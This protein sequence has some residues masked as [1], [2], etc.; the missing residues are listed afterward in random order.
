M[1]LT[2][3]IFIY[4]IRYDGTIREGDD[5]PSIVIRET[6]SSGIKLQDRDIVILSHTIV[7]KALGL[8]VSLSKVRPGPMAISLAERFGR[9]P[10]A[11]EIILRES[12]AIARAERNR[13]ITLARSGIVSANSQVDHSNVGCEDEVVIAPRNPDVIARRMRM[14]FQS[15]GYDVAVILTDTLGRPFRLGEV[16][17]AMGCAGI[18]PI[19][20]LRGKADLYGM[21]LRIKRIA[22]VDELAA[23]SELVTGS[24]SEGVIGAIVRGYRY[25]GSEMGARSLARPVAKELFL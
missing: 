24:S 16:N 23:S 22:I 3:P 6:E 14:R 5:L 4:G 15:M 2:N 8:K 18:A 12:R 7:S 13:L 1:P 10:E 11:V 19:N 20:D 9:R 21:I 25:E 17:F